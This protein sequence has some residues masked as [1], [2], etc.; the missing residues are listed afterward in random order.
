M[1]SATKTDQRD[2][3]GRKVLVDRKT[4]ETKE[5]GIGTTGPVSLKI[6]SR[7]GYVIL[8]RLVVSQ[9]GQLANLDDDDVYDLKLAV[10]EA[11]TNAIRHAAVEYFEI[12]YHTLP[13]AI[14][15]TVSDAGG[16]FEVNDLTDIP[17]SQGGFGLA[18]IRSLV[19]EVAIESTVEG[20][21]LRMI[22]R[23]PTPARSETS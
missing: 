17:D 1:R 11:A 16:G 12:K 4:T 15:I 19:D 7:A 9:I 18:V 20:T 21:Q 13:D 14:E 10:T 22:R 6:P 5:E 8:A 23:I 3:G 2:F